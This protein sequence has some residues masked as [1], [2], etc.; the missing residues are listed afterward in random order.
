[1]GDRVL[2]SR[3][4]SYFLFLGSKKISCGPFL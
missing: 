3:E 2:E 4:L 1:L